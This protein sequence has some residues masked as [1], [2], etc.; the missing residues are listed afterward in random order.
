MINLGAKNKRREKGK[1]ILGNTT[2]TFLI[3]RGK[4][5]TKIRE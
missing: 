3:T 2:V 1:R 4:W 5:G